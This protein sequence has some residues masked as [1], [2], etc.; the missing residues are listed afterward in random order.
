[1]VPVE[2]VPVVVVMAPVGVVLLLAAG[3]RLLLVAVLLDM[4]P[5]P[6][7]V[8]ALDRCFFALFFVELVNFVRSLAAL[9]QCVLQSSRAF[10]FLPQPEIL[11]MPLP[12]CFAQ[13]PFPTAAVVHPSTYLHATLIRPPC[14]PH[15]PRALA[16]VV[17]PV[18]EHTPLAPWPQHNPRATRMLLHPSILH[19]ER[20]PLTRFGAFLIN[21]GVGNGAGT[22]EPS[23]KPKNSFLINDGVSNGVDAAKDLVEGES[24][25]GAEPGMIALP[26]SVLVATALAIAAT[27]SICFTQSVCMLAAPAVQS[28]WAQRRIG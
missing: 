14:L 10:A 23:P 25:G 20:L 3:A 13:R 7:P 16:N 1:M 28:L 4:L 21:D 22:A 26:E 11:Q 17:H 15:N 9:P 24:R 12:P 2:M 5:L 19:I 6:A 27:A 8:V 18:C